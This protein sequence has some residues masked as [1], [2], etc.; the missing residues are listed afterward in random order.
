MIP[1][2]KVNISIADN[3]IGHISEVVKR[4]KKVGLKVDQVFNTIGVVTGSIESE[5]FALL[6]DVEGIASIE[7]EQKYEIAPPDSNLQ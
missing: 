6:K 1:I 3:Y 4:S 2:L 5:K 7:A